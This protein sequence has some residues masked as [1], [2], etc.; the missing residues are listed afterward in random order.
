MR[1]E[2]FYVG[3][4]PKAPPGLSQ[5]LRRIVL[6]LVS[7]VVV[8]AVALVRGQA[9]FPASTFEFQKYRD[10]DGV[11]WEHPYP[12]LLGSRSSY[13]LVAPG[14]HGAGE[15][16]KGFDGR[17]V[18]LKG[19]LIY[20]DGTTMIEVVPNSVQSTGGAGDSPARIDLGAVTLRGEIVDSK[21]YLG[22]MNPGNGKVHRDCAARCISGGIPP[23][24]VVKDASGISK[25]LLLA[26]SD[27]RVIDFVAEPVEVSGRLSRSG[28][29]LILEANPSSI[30]RIGRPTWSLLAGND[31]F[32]AGVSSSSRW[33]SK[34]MPARKRH[35]RPGGLH[36]TVSHASR[37]S[38]SL[39][40]YQ[41]AC[42]T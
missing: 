36:S 25:T 24:F 29:L 4:L 19:S 26:G 15:M 32:R 40:G 34:D 31:G 7:V 14:K 8:V 39:A 5:A 37:R 38:V 22:V 30:R 27:R 11:L 6:G 18:R 16:V 33:P 17:R 1:Q 2:E 9:P 21:C 13:L 42:P 3:Y 28:D 12:S 35:G 23:A 41:G 10:F 20:R